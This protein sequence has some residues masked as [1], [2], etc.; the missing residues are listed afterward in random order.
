MYKI[1]KKKNSFIAFLSAYYIKL[2]K[3]NIY[4]YIQFNVYIYIH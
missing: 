3:K 4:I 1:E 2:E